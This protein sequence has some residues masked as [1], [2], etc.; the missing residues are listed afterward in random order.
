M[1]ISLFSSKAVPPYNNLYLFAI[2]QGKT[3]PELHELVNVYKPDLLWSDGH[4][5]ASAEYFTSK[6]FLAWLF[7]DRCVSQHLPKLPCI[8]VWYLNVMWYVCLH[9]STSYVI[10]NGIWSVHVY[11]FIFCI[12][13]Y[14]ACR[15]QCNSRVYVSSPVKEHVVVNDRWG[16]T[17]FCK[18][19][20]Y[21]TCSDR[22]NPKVSTVSPGVI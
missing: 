21:L 3:I 5:M 20:S 22:Y 11:V 4:W 19:G 12:W 18:H 16:N 7:N 10:L 13:D 6:E 2:S 15:C 9:Y 1:R 14:T 8:L 17:T